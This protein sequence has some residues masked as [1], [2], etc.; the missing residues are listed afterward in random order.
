MA[1]WHRA[2]PIAGVRVS[3]VP[4]SADGDDAMDGGEICLGGPGIA[5]GY[6]NQVTKAF[7]SVENERS[8]FTGDVGQW[9]L[10]DLGEDER[11]PVRKL[12]VLGSKR[13]SGETEWRTD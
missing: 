5:R 9:Y 8:Y 2:P 3:L 13:S 4:W 1:T 11:I 10:D 12:Q 7:R 6:L